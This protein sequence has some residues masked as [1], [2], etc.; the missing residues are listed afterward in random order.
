MP[1]R[2][3]CTVVRSMPTPADTAATPKR[4][5]SIGDE[6]LKNSKRQVGPFGG[7]LSFLPILRIV[8]RMKTPARLTNGIRRVVPCPRGANAHV[9]ALCAL[10][11]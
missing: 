4:I 8:D 6:H 1:M 9:G 10:H 3:E 5:G 11:C 2:S 7:L